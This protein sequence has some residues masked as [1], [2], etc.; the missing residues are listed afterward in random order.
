MANELIYTASVD[1]SGAL[2]IVNRKGF[3]QD[4]QAFAGQRIIMRIKKYRKS[5]SNKQ[6]NYYWGCV[7]PYVQDGLNDMGFDRHLISAENVHHML[8]DKFLKE[9]IG[10][11][12]GEHAGEFV[13][14]VRSTSDLSTTEF[15]DYIADIQKWSMEFLNKYIPDPGEQSEIEY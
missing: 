7:I 15:M 1:E 11:T 2:K 14:M 6:N 3:D 9:D 8:R 10:V 5:R 13:T 4:M 12:D